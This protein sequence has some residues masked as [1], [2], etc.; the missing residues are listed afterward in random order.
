MSQPQPKHWL[1][2]L[3]EDQRVVDSLTE[4]SRRHNIRAATRPQSL[5]WAYVV[6]LALAIIIG[7]IMYN[8]GLNGGLGQ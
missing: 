3:H 8:V 5:S 2:Q 7:E 1:D 6:V 4:R